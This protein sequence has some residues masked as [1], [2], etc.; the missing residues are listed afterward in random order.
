MNRIRIERTKRLLVLTEDPLSGIAG[1]AGFNNEYYLN[2]R[3]K[4]TVGITP[5]QYRRNHREH[6]RVFAPCLEDF[7]LALEITP[8][9]QWYSEGWGKQDYLGMGDVPVF[10]VSDGSLEGLTKEKPDFILLDGGTHPSGYSRLAPTY[11][12]AHPGETGN[13]RWIKRRICSERR[14]ASGTLSASTKVGRTKQNRPSNA[15]FAIRRW[16]S[17]AF[18]PKPLSCTGA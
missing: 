18:Q 17:C 8:V 16:R 4:Q 15:P 7:L 14:A 2:R 13:P 9:M 6:V 10:D 12:M 11:T 5:G 1:D 3:F